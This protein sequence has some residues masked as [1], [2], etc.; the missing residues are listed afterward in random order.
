MPAG[1]DCSF[2]IGDTVTVID[3]PLG[4]EVATRVVERKADLLHPWRV[5]VKLDTPLD[6][7]PDT[8]EF[9]RDEQEKLLRDTRAGL[10]EN[11][12]AAEA[13][14]ARLGFSN[15]AFRFFGA[16]TVGGWDNL[17]WSAGTLRVGNGWYA[18][19]SGSV[20]SLSANT[21]YYFYFDRTSPTAFG[22]T[23]TAADAESEDRILLFT[24]RTTTSPTPLN[25]YPLGVI[26]V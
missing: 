15:Y 9:I 7:R 1:V 4:I 12:Q 22:S 10:A 2:G 24:A 16:V 5:S 19:S 26:H 14:S 17:S 18:I 23:T 25:I 13:G 20:S 3:E 6:S 21:E 8:I 11:S